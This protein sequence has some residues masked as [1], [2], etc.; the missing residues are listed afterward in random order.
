M[1]K[2]KKASPLSL[3]QCEAQYRQ[4]C[5]SLAAVGWISEGYVQDR[6]PGAAA[7]DWQYC[8]YCASHWASE[9]GEAFLDFVMNRSVI[10]ASIER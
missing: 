6:G 10:H 4:Y 9:S 5:Q 7:K 2:S 1:T 8:R 3:A